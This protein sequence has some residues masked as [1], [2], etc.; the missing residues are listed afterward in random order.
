MDQT[1]TR[2]VYSTYGSVRG[3]CGHRHQS[4]GA[5]EKCLAHDQAGCRSQGGYSDRSIVL[6]GDDGYLYRDMGQMAAEDGDH[7]IQKNGGTG[8]TIND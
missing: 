5:A 6:V 7:W 3:C 2:I 1:T 8:A 4:M